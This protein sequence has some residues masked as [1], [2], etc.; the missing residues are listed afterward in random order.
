MSTP[1]DAHGDGEVGKV[2]ITLH[3]A[4]CELGP[5]GLL[6]GTTL[7]LGE[8]FLKC[9]L[10]AQT[11][12]PE[13]TVEDDREENNDDD[14]DTQHA[15]PVNG[16]TENVAEEGC[17]HQ[18]AQQLHRH[19]RGT[20]EVVVCPQCLELFAAV[21]FHHQGMQEGRE[22]HNGQN[23]N[24]NL[25]PGIRQQTFNERLGELE[26]KDDDGIAKHTVDDDDEAYLLQVCAPMALLTYNIRSAAGKVL[27][28]V[29]PANGQTALHD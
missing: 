2:H 16:V 20:V 27:Q 22:K 10:Q 24:G 5:V 17:T 26:H 25:V 15:A 18:N 13:A 29:L 19:Q 14:K 3:Q 23:G 9:L 28:R 21:A 12:F 6:E 7:S 8:V 4:A 11:L 1:V